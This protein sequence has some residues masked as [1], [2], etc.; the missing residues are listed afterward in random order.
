MVF[1]DDMAPAGDA[2]VATPTTDDV[3]ADAPAPTEEKPS[4]E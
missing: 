4:E 1:D 2:P 3:V